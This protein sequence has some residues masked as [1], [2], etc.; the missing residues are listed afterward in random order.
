MGACFDGI[1]CPATI[2]GSWP[3]LVIKYQLYGRSRLVGSLPGSGSQPH[4][5]KWP[6]SPD[7]RATIGLEMAV[8]AAVP[9]GGPEQS[10]Q[11][12]G[13]GIEQQHPVAALRVG[14]ADRRE[15]AY[16]HDFGHPFS[17]R[18]AHVKGELSV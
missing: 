15:P 2:K 1:G 13:E 16:F 4:H 3:L 11:D 6:R 9:A 8:Q 17:S 5:Q 10:E 18:T 12:D 7:C 14:D